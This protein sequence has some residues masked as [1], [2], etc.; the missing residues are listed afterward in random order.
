MKTELEKLQA[1]QLEVAIECLDKYR[2]L[3]IDDKRYKTGG[4]FRLGKHAEDA[5]NL[6]AA[7]RRKSKTSQS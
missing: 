5:L 6:M 4:V 1:R 7:I 2:T 3:V